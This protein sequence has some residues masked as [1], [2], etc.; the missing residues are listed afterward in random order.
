[1]IRAHEHRHVFRRRAGDQGVAHRRPRCGETCRIG[2]ERGADFVAGGRQM[3]DDDFLAVAPAPA[4]E[5]PLLPRLP[6]QPAPQHPRAQAELPRQRRPDGGVAERVRRVQGLATPA[7]VL[8][9]GRAV[10]QVAHQRLSRRHL[11]V[12]LDVPGPYLQPVGLHQGLH[13]GLPVGPG[14]HVILEENRL[15]VEQE[16][17]VGRVRR[18]PRHEVVQHRNEPRVQRRAREVPL[19]VP[20]RVGDQVEDEAAHRRARLPFRG[21]GRQGILAPCANPCGC[22]C[23]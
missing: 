14:P 7:P 4:I 12:R 23:R 9:V 1:M 15:A 18:E 21:S 19:A 20:V 17:A 5:V 8:G 10:E 13:V 3:P 22:S 2:R 11:L 16:G 6:T